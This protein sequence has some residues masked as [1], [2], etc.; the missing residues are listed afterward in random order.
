MHRCIRRYFSALPA[1]SLRQLLPSR[2]A[3]ACCAA[4]SAAAAASQHWLM[5]GGAAAAAP[6]FLRQA[7]VH[8]GV[9]GVCLAALAAALYRQERP[10]FA[11]LLHVRSGKSD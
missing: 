1:F 9:G 5:A 3:L 4:A 11:Q 10:A 8:V 2:R 6:Q 7:A